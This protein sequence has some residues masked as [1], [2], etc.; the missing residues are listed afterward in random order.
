MLIP[1]TS[2][3]IHIIA[4]SLFI[5]SG[6]PSQ[7]SEYGSCR[8]M[9]GLKINP[10]RWGNWRADER[11]VHVHDPHDLE[12]RTSRQTFMTLQVYRLT[13]WPFFNSLISQIPIYYNL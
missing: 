10:G 8:L 4:V 6:L 3:S 12:Q 1:M 13:V 5:E 7:L 9:F 2:M 11:T